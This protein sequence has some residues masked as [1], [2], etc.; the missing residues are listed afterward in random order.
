[1]AEAKFNRVLFVPQMEGRSV[2]SIDTTS[3]DPEFISLPVDFQSMERLRLS[4]VTGKPV[5]EYRSGK[6][7]DEYR[8]M[9]DN[10]TGQPRFFTVMGTELELC[11]TPVSNYVLEMFYRKTVPPLASNSTNW[12]LL[13]APDVYMYGSLVEAAPFMGEDPR[14]A[15]WQGAFDKAIAELNG[16]GIASEGDAKPIRAA[17]GA[18]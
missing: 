17:A 4:S 1:M 2:T 8:T 3:T 7:V 6:Q 11:P 15:L 10:V 14:I 12:L 16:L 18:R 13:L 5:L 9:I